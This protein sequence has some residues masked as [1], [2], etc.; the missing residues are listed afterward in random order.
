MLGV[1]GDEVLFT[2]SRKPTETHL[3]SYRDGE[4]VRQLSTEPGVHSGVR[5]DGT[6]V[7][8]ALGGDGPGGHVTVVKVGVPPCCA[9]PTYFT[10]QWQGPE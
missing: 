6:L 1:D 7:D 10:P 4:G 8:V 9:D 2:A 5:R 3:F